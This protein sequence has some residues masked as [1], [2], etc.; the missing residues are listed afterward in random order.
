M[1]GLLKQL[2][3]LLLPIAIDAGKK[4]IEKK[5]QPKPKG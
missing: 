3:M 2:A 1:K 4:A 5:L